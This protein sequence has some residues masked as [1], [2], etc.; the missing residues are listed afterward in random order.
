MPSQRKFWDSQTERY[1]KSISDHDDAYTDRLQSTLSLLNQ[2][3]TV[4][5]LGCASGEIALDIAPHV[6]HIHGIDVS[7]KMIRLATRKTT[8][9]GAQN[10]SFA[11]TDL[12][13]QTLTPHAYDAVL[14]FNVLHLIDSPARAIARLHEL[15]TPNGLLISQTPCI[16]DWHRAK[17][18]L[19][20]LAFGV[21]FAPR[22]HRFT[23]N[24]L[25]T[26]I[27][28]NGFTITENRITEPETQTRW[29]TAQKR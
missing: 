13:D 3:D 9:R 25:Q 6:N 27:A 22:I 19:I 1:E 4:L 26:L 28:S 18:F 16:G 8:S 7:P 10:T 5:D 17:K 29:I 23:Q 12:F 15:L 21:G 2:T 24:N 11:T 20:R 14:V